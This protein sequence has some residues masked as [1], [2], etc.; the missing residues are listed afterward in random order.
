MKLTQKLFNPT[1][2][3]GVVKQPVCHIHMT[4]RSCHILVLQDITHRYVIT[5]PNARSY[6]CF[7]FLD[8]TCDGVLSRVL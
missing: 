8:F 2:Q 4:V 7:S 6:A 3:F 5:T 1:P